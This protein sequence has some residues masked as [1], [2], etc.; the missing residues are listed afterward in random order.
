MTNDKQ[1]KDYYDDFSNW[2]E[3]ERHH[4]YHA[5]LDK[6]ELEV[7]TPMAANREVLEVGAGTGLIMNGL[8]GCAGRIVGL[9]ISVGMLETAAARGLE[10][11]QGSATDLPFEDGRFDLTYS[12]KVLAH[13]PDIERALFEMARVTKSG[14]YMVAELYNAQSLRYVAKNVGGPQKISQER[15]EAEVFTRWDT[16]EEILGYLPDTVDF[17]AW[18]GIRVLTPAAVAFKIPLVSTVLPKLESI[19]AN[20]PLARFGGFLIAVSQKK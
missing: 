20:S 2:Y 19:A 17:E 7:L 14:G 8:S 3:R 16:P 12:L 5:M 4:G 9:D 13:V 11:V 10:V 15:T 6:L 18:R 1:T